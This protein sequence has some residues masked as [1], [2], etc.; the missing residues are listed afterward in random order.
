[1]LSS[2]ARGGFCGAGRRIFGSLFLFG[3][4][5]LGGGLGSSSLGR[6]ILG[7]LGRRSRRSLLR[8]ASGGL[9]RRLGVLVVIEGHQGKINRTNY[10]WLSAVSGCL[11]VPLTSRLISKARAPAKEWVRSSLLQVQLGIQLPNPRSGRFGEGA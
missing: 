3:S 2:A 9:F 7:S 10:L 1:M 11:P 6:S 5:S 4:G 8:G